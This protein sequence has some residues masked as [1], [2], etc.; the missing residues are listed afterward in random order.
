M[1]P[2]S[3]QQPPGLVTN[4][5]ITYLNFYYADSQISCVLLT[6]TQLRVVF[7][8]WRPGTKGVYDL[9]LRQINDF[10]QRGN[11]KNELELDLAIPVRPANPCTAELRTAWGPTTNFTSTLNPHL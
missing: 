4:S 11:R 6:N 2:V 7:F 3:Q 1:T 10:L 8:G 5:I 9:P